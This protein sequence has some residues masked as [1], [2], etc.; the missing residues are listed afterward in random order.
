MNK[1]LLTEQKVGTLSYIKESAEK[2]DSTVL[3]KLRGVCAECDSPTRNGRTYSKKLWEKVLKSETF[4][5]YLNTKCLFGELNHPED[6]LDTDISKAAV[7]LREISFEGNS[8]IGTF[9]ILPTPCGEILKTLCNYGSQLGVSSRGGG[10]VL[11]KEGKEFVD[12]ES[13]DFVAFD[14]VALPAVKNA[15]PK[16]IESIEYEKHQ[17]DLKESILKQIETSTSSELRS[18]K[19]VLEKIELPEK[20]MILETLEN[21]IESLGGETVSPGILE[22]LQMTIQKLD[23]SEKLVA[24]LTA[25]ISAGTTREQ[26]L[27]EDLQKTQQS[28]KTL[29]VKSKKLNALESIQSKNLQESKLQVEKKESEKKMLEDRI[30]ILSSSAKL[31]SENVKAESKALIE[32]K[33]I[34]VSTENNL[35]ESLQQ[36]DLIKKEKEDSEKSNKKLIESLKKDKELITQKFITKLNEQKSLLENKSKL[37]EDAIARYIS[38]YCRYNNL[39]ESQ[40]VKSVSD[41]NSINSVDKALSEAFDYKLRIEKLPF[42]VSNGHQKIQLVSEEFQESASKED[43]SSLERMLKRLKQ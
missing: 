36:L 9:D 11:M 39:S 35:K 26:K 29:A 34:L 17:T 1:V 28:L 38:L 19:T 16:M 4:N 20:K 10:E 33:A 3:G 13:Y 6:R 41:L 12:E 18:I 14:I 8:V 7:A 43:N 25:K 30:S 40:I 23:E 5:E 42:N 27:L 2:Q 24:D 31:V 32:T 15:R 22:D 21:K 37:S